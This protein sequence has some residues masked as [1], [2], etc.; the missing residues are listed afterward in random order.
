MPFS[1]AAMR[2]KRLKIPKVSCRAQ[3]LRVP[4]ASHACTS[5]PLPRASLDA[6][7]SFGE[8]NP[9]ISRTQ[10]NETPG[11]QR[12]GLGERHRLARACDVE[13]GASGNE[14]LLRFV[15]RR[16]GQRHAPLYGPPPNLVYPADLVASLTSINQTRRLPV[17]SLFMGC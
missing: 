1:I 3:G 16:R 11:L 15:E 12:F 2:R 6:S 14:L 7:H 10:M 4:C 9:A 17:P 8:L 5:D 13:G